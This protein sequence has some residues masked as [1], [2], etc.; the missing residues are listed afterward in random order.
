MSNDGYKNCSYCDEDTTKAVAT[1]CRFDMGSTLTHK[2]LII[3]YFLSGM[4]TIEVD[5]C[6]FHSALSVDAYL[7]AFD[8]HLGM[9]YYRM[10]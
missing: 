7:K 9:R 6:D 5:D 10:P 8:N 2:N 3:E 1:I 4:I